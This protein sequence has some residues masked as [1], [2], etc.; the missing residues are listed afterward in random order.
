MSTTSAR[1]RVGILGATG[2]VGQRLVALL[3][4]HPWFEVAVCGASSRSEGRS[5]GDAVRWS[6]P[7]DVP[8]RVAALPVVACDPA[9]FDGCHVVLSG[10]DSAAARDLEP[11]FV[12]AGHAVVSNA[13]AH[14]MA[15]A[16][17]LVIPEVNAHHLDLVER[18]AAEGAG[19]LVTNPN[20]SV[21]GLAVALAPLHRAFG[22]RRAVVAT[23]QALSG[24]GIEGPTAMTM[25]D[26]VIPYIA[27]EEDKMNEEL[28]KLLGSVSP[29]RDRVVAAP[30]PV[31]AHCHRVA[32]L[33]GHLEAVSIELERPVSVAGAVET[34]RS[35]RGPVAGMGLPSAPERPIVVR[36]EPDRPQPRL[37]RDA[38]AGMT[39]VVGR[40]RPCP[41][42]TL[43][44]E[45]LSHNTIRGAAGA[46]LL[47]AELL[48][49][50]G[51]LEGRAPR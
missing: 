32:T 51:W 1:M 20:C 24:A 19:F 11:A 49:A 39:V 43:R 6:L 25:T 22:I 31:S 35:F 34:L 44:F 33:D 45:L 50:R 5:Y 23:M 18:R 36:D 16:T 14:R 4:G 48:A 37:D 42:M 21:I 17:P 30:I 38:G 27:G 29:E 15:P 47:N 28:G 8:D 9:A 7:G 41:A 2:L 3:D 13:S 26:N 12:A 46:A 40:V 10:L